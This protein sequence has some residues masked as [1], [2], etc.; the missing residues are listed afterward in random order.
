MYIRAVGIVLHEQ[1]IL[2]MFRRSDGRDYFVFPGGH[3][4]ERE[5]PAETAA[6]EVLEE[7]CVSVSVDRLIYHHFYDDG[8]ER[9]YFLCDYLIGEPQLGEGPE[10]EKMSEDN[11]YEPRWV[12]LERLSQTLVYPLEIRDWI[13]QDLKN[14]FPQTPRI[15][16]IVF[17]NLRQTL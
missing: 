9:F 13:L 15:E 11:Y 16:Q 10:K 3:V 2:L 1:N 17:Q 5:L 12:P 7:T 8:S 14:G 6:R 4:E